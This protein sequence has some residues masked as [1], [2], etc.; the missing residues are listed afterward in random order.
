MHQPGRLINTDCWVP[1]SEF[2]IPQVLGAL[3]IHM[4]KKLLGDADAPCLGPTLEDHCF[5]KSVPQR[6]VSRNTC[7]KHPLWFSLLR[8]ISE[9][10]TFLFTCPICIILKYT[11]SKKD[12]FLPRNF[13]LDDFFS[14][15]VP[16]SFLIYSCG[17]K[18]LKHEPKD[19]V[20]SL[21]LPLPNQ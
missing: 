19:L 16:L 5:K 11:F 7:L 20:S 15:R 6:A 2:L 3:R 12:L 21:A 8:F 9:P 10:C 13:P 1:P 18:A 4:S 14:P 17:G